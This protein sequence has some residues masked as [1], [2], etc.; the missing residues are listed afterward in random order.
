M[1]FGAVDMNPWPCRSRQPRGKAFVS[2]TGCPGTP[3]WCSIECT[4]GKSDDIVSDVGGGTVRL[5][6]DVF[7]TF[8]WDALSISYVIYIIYFGVVVYGTRM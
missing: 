5:C 2:C 7:F 1:P 8:N 3:T 4:H 6:S